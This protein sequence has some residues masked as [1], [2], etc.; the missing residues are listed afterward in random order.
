LKRSLVV[1]ISA[2]ALLAGACSSGP[3]RLGP[4]TIEPPRG[5]YVSD[6]EPESIKVTNGTI[7][8]DNS[9][10][11]GTA[12]AVFDV[13]I[14]ST[15]TVAEFRKALKKGNAAPK[16]ERLRVDGYDAVIV[17][18]ATSYFGPSSDVLIV[19]E[20]NV[21]AVYRAARGDDEATFARH[22]PD[23]RSAVTSIRFSGRPPDRA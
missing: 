10:S 1:V 5:W 19:P 9:T 12:T 18:Y 17:S 22:R 15:Q 14:N 11:P 3:P 6:R 2:F 4:L 20:W 13:Y 16:E 23:F 7:A 21:R 8:D